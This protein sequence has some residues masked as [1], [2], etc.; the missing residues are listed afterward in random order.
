[1]LVQRG[2]ADA[3]FITPDTLAPGEAESLV[4]QIIRVIEETRQSTFGSSPP[5]VR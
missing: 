1:V 4:A 2:D 3:F 5:R